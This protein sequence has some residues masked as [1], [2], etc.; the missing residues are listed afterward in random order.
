M[1]P[2][3][4]WS[5]THAV[6]AG[7]LP[8]WAEPDPARPPVTSL[9]Q[10]LD[11]VVEKR[12]GAWARV[13]AVNGWTGW[14]DGRQLVGIVGAGAQP[15]APAVAAQ[16][17]P[18]AAA[19]EAGHVPQAAQV[20]RPAQAAPQLPVVPAYP[21]AFTPESGGAAQWPGMPA[22]AYAPRK[23]RTP[24][25]VAIVVLVVVLLSALGVGAYV[26]ATSG[27]GS[28]SGKTLF[29][30]GSATGGYVLAEAVC[31]GDKTGYSSTAVLMYPSLG[32]SAR[33][34]T[35]TLTGDLKGT[36]YGVHLFLGTA[37]T[38][39]ID[40]Q[41]VLNQRGQET[42]LA[43]A[44]LT[45]TGSTYKDYSADVTGSDPATARGD[46][47]V[48]RITPASGSPGGLVFSNNAAKTS[49]IEIPAVG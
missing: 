9:A 27:G 2:G 32:R 26:V 33:D 39:T 13:R 5:P 28:A 8:A 7:G 40:V 41:I 21:G 12:S 34:F 23:S 4:G 46:L 20:A 49:F 31:M 25:V 16:A 17:A 24:I 6:P 14:V 38:M 15:V 35:Y 18:G 29:L 36:K 22:Q 30:C 1:G 44:S 3:K 19:A 11:L 10:G 43:S 45:A 47:L 37:G 42:I 48:L